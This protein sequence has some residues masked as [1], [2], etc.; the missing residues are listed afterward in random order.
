M[1][2]FSIVGPMNHYPEDMPNP[3]G[4][5]T[6]RMALSSDYLTRDNPQMV[7]DYLLIV[8]LSLVFHFYMLSFH[9]F[10]NINYSLVSETC[11]VRYQF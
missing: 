7:R 3:Y 5:N 1:C 11:F 9:G 2:S 8:K 6:G 10:I 4:A